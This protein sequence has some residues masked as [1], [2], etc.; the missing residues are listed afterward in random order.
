MLPFMQAPSDAPTTPQPAKR[1]IKSAYDWKRAQFLFAQGFTHRQISEM[2]NIPL[3]TIAWRSSK[4]Q[5]RQIKKDA[6]LTIDQTSANQWLARTAN[7]RERMA[8]IAERNLV[9]IEASETPTSVKGL[10]EWFEA[11]DKLDRIGRRQ[12]GLD[13]Q[14]GAGPS[15]QIVTSGSV[16]VRGDDASMPGAGAGES[17]GDEPIDV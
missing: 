6:A 1:Q 10:S 5:W 8:T 15:V 12:F 2:L 4:G 7:W 17:A 11:L 16:L 3:G 13:A 14:A 9:Q